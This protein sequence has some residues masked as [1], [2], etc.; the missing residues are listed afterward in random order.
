VN[1]GPQSPPATCSA[2]ETSLTPSA[3]RTPAQSPQRPPAPGLRVVATIP[4]PG[5]TN[6]F[7]YQSF[8]G[9]RRRLYINHMN[10]GHL[11]TFDVDSHRVTHDVGNLPRATGVWAVPEH[12]DVYVSSAGAHASIVLDDR[13]LAETTRVDG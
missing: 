6:R 1:V 10:A 13:T 3:W 7:D 2:S 9:A 11:L 12:H 4:L 5:P 8:D